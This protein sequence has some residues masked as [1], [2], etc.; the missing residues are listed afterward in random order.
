MLREIAALTDTS[1]VMIERAYARHIAT[2]DA[3]TARL[4]RLLEAEK[5]PAAPPVL[6]V[7]G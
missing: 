6:R 7:V 5:A 4:R 2:T 1:A 3:T